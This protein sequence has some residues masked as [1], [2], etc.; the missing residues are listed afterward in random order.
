MRIDDLPYYAVGDIMPQD[1]I[2]LYYSPEAA[3]DNRL[4]PLERIEVCH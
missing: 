1:D 4:L 2:T 3:K